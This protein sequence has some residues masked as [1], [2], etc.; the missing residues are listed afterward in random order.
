MSVEKQRPDPQK[1]LVGFR[2]GDVSYAVPIGT[3]REIIN[4]VPLTALPHPPPAVDGVAD[5]RGEVVPVINLRARFGLGST[6]EQRREKWILIAV[7]GRTVGIVVDQVTDV[8]GTGGA[9]LR[10]PPELGDGDARRGL[11]GVTNYDGELVF[12]LDV[13]RFR[14]LTAPLDH[15]LLNGE[16]SA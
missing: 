7:E 6:T 14:D 2:V 5:H 16:G 9:E 15:A 10:P 11:A 12:V 1:S 8:F 4:P 13:D 3:V